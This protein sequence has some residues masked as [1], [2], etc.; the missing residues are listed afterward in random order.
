M[1]EIKHP[2]PIGTTVKYK[3]SN[4]EEKG[5]AIIVG[6]EQDDED[7]HWYYVLDIV[8][9]NKNTIHVNNRGEPSCNDFEIK[10]IVKDIKNK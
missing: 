7:G 5:T 2:L 9:G 4:E 10:S 8:E 6:R 3:I 1:K